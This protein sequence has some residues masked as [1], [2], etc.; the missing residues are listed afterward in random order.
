M[1]LDSTLDVTKYYN[2]LAKTIEDLKNSNI[3]TVTSIFKK[4]KSMID[5]LVLVPQRSPDACKDNAIVK[6]DQELRLK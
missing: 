1:V 4:I 6:L 5:P 3:E 2:K